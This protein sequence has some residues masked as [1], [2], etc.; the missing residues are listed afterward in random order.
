MGGNNNQQAEAKRPSRVSEQD[1]AI[2]VS[3]LER[4]LYVVWCNVYIQCVVRSCLCE[5]TVTIP[6]IVIEATERQVAQVSEESKRL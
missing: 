5:P 1:K 4:G 2:L 3:Y 6:Y